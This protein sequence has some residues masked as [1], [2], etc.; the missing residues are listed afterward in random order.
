MKHKPWVGW[1]LSERGELSPGL[2]WEL[3]D[4]KLA[5]EWARE[6]RRNLPQN[7]PVCVVKVRIEVVE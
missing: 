2:G 4:K 1:M 6:T 5:L 3:R 7:K